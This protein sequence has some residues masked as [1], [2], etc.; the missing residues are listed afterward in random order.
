VPEF[1]AQIFQTTDG[2]V[3][4]GRVLSQDEKTVRVQV[5]PYGGAPVELSIEEIE[6]RATSN[7]SVMPSGLLSTFERVEILELLAYL[8]SLK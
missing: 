3:V 8:S 1:L 4:A 2:R 5:D 7:V 6:E